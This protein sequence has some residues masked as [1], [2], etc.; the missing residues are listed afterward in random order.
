M[1]PHILPVLLGAD[2][3]CYHLARSFHQ[4]YSVRSR[5]FGRYPLGETSH[6][7]ILDFTAVE[8]LEDSN[9]L[10][11]TLRQLAASTPD[12]TRIVLGCTDRYAARLAALRPQ[13]EP[14]Y[15]V[16]Y[17]DPV[18]IKQ[19][20][21]KASFGRICQKYGLSTPKT[22]LRSPRTPLPSLPFSYPVILKPADSAVYW[23][24]P[25]PGMEKVYLCHSPAQ[26][27]AVLEKADLAGYDRRF[28]F[29]EYLPGE[30]WQSYVVTAY[31]DA[32]AKV[33]S[34]CIAQVLCEEHTPKGRGNPAAVLTM[35]H[36][37]LCEQLRALLEGE[38][39]I[40]FSNFDFKVDAKDGTPYLLEMNARQGRSSFYATAA[41]Q[42]LAQSVVEDRVLGKP[43]RGCAIAKKEIYWRYLPDGLVRANIPPKLY[44]ICRRAIQEG[45]GVRS[46]HY[47][48]DLRGNP[49]RRLWLFAH[50]FRYYAKFKQFRS[51][52][53]NFHRPPRPAVLPAKEPT[54]KP[55]NAGGVFG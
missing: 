31:S 30:D 54:P 28:L 15:I 46:L 12:R 49:L 25:F 2:L 36:D 44:A 6:S 4:A 3:N 17:G 47:A 55:E 52:Q 33:R 8:G 27:E 16:P 34:I 48:P 11:R 21:D 19:L 43:Y 18:K 24:H 10:L 39:F 22:V 13:L 32:H 42:N 50:E 29:Q 41:G 37:R 45:R 35:R 26:A 51:L 40:G 23:N 20:T 14:D 53:E 9:V 7:K 1:R 5:V 38:G